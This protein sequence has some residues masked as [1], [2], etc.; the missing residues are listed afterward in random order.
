MR[1]TAPLPNAVR[2]L[3]PNFARAPMLLEL[4]IV[5]L[6]ATPVTAGARTHT[7][8]IDPK[9][10][11]LVK[12]AAS[13]YALK[14]YDL[15]IRTYT[16]AL[17]M[18]PDTTT[19][20]AIHDWRAHAYFDKGDWDQAINDADESIRLNPHYFGGYLARAIIFRRS[21]NLDQAISYYD[22]AIRL[23][24]NF[25]RSYYDRATAHALKGEYDAAIRDGTEAIRRGDRT[26]L[27]DF[28]YNRAVSYHAIGSTN[29]AL[30]DYNEAIRRD[31]N[32]LEHYYGRGEIFEDIGE[33]D[34]A[35]ADYDRATRYNPTNAKGYIFRGMA[36]FANGNYRAAASDFEKAAELSPRDYDALCNLAWFQATCP[37]HS[38]RNG[39]AAL[40]NATRACELT[41]WQHYAPVDT[42]AAAY[43]DIG[44]FD[45]AVKYE[46]RAINMKG[47]YGFERKKMQQRLELYRQ[48]KPYRKESKFKPP[49]Q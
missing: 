16:A 30:A 3:A 21:G 46:T 39:K 18:N 36:N 31:P 44:N 13:E 40:E 29:E 37:D 43:A 24:P 20:A 49:Q 34:K 42:S 5:A 26:M 15:A 38:L 2:L 25:S 47:V 1:L 28:Y 23:N 14:R 9:V 22:T 7:V 12:K 41:H 4:I 10:K 11:P 27:A 45:D 8:P 33:L 48:H 19:A 35:K 6:A 32:T 17:Q